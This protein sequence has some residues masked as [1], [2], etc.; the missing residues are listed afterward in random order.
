MLDMEIL[1]YI[2]RTRTVKMKEKKSKK[3]N[4]SQRNRTVRKSEH[5]NSFLLLAFNKNN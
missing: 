4:C 1:P 3:R 2:N 5:T